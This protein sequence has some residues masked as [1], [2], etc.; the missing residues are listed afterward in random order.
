MMNKAILLVGL[1]AL[2]VGGA[3]G[4]D[5][6]QETFFRH[7]FHRLPHVLPHPHPHRPRVL[8]RPKYTGP[9]PPLP[10]NLPE[11]VAGIDACKTDL[12]TYLFNSNHPGSAS[13]QCCSVLENDPRPAV[14]FLHTLVCPGAAAPTPSA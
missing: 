9:L 2:F 10:A 14:K 11:I 4:Q 3:F 6:Q 7:P 1:L 13:A 12:D 8:P 5:V